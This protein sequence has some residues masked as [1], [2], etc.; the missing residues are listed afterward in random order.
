M[1]VAAHDLATIEDGL[2]GHRF[3]DAVLA[4]NRQNGGWVSIEA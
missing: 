3:I 2:S 1:P 4:S